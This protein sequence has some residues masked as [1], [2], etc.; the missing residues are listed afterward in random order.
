MA[1]PNCLTCQQPFELADLLSGLTGYATLT[2]SGTA[3]CPRCGAGLEFRVGA[4]TL[5]LGY[6]YFGGSMHFEALE[7]FPVSGLR[8]RRN[9]HLVSIEHRGV[10]YAPP[11]TS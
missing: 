11:V 8:Q 10:L 2:D 4:G 3:P 5:E 6:T 1:T 9:G 7:T